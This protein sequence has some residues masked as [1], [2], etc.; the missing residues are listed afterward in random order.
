MILKDK[1]VIVTGVGPGMGR[2]LCIGAAREGAKVVLA[3]R[4]EKF[5]GEV[6]AEITA[7]G[8]EALV[9]PSDVALD[10]DCKRIVE[11][12]QSRFGRI[13]GLVNSAYFHP[14]FSTLE[15]ADFEEWKKAMD[16]ACFGAL[17]MIRAVVPAM[18]AQ[19]G[20]TIVNIGTLTTRK[21]MPG[22][23][24]YA[25]A[26]SALSQVTRHMATELGPHNIR[27]NQA[28]MGWMMGA[29]LRGYFERA[30]QQSGRPVEAFISDVAAR[31]PLG[32]VPEDADCAKAVLMLLSDYSSE[33]TGAMIDVNG[34]EYMPA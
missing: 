1:V 22:E 20:G 18:K 17:R 3:A 23:T 31:I 9:V 11:Q 6:A 30:S 8:G 33:M 24:G 34:G 28:L 32:R 16:V 4:S 13:D 2:H 29:P 21:P 19:G 10:P 5:L 27:V 26:K 12:G 25:I 15:E 7:K 14:M